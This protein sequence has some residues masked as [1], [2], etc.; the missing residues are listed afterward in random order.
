MLPSF[1]IESTGSAV[2]LTNSHLA[3]GE[4]GHDLFPQQYDKACIFQRLFYTGSS[5]LAGVHASFGGHAY[6]F[7]K[8]GWVA[9]RPGT[10]LNPVAP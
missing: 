4:N 2:S 10:N 7:G 5:A 9:R 6:V 1:G 8:V 3:A